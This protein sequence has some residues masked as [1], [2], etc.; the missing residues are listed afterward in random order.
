MVRTNAAGESVQG[1]FNKVACMYHQLK[2]L[3]CSTPSRANVV[4]FLTYSYASC[5]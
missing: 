4:V 1:R 5:Y 2:S 3:Q